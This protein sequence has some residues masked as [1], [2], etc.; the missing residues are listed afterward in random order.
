MQSP[1]KY[2]HVHVATAAINKKFA[3]HI[4]T[5]ILLWYAF[6]SLVLCSVFVEPGVKHS[7]NS[8][9]FVVNYYILFS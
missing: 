9:R 1:V 2:I 5:A 7:S 6:H 8:T 4:H 3:F